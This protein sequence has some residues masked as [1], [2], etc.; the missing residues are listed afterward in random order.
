M[1]YK[2]GQVVNLKF[3]E[4]YKTAD[5]KTIVNGKHPVLVVDVFSN[6]KIRIASMSSNMKQIQKHRPH[7]IVLDD[8]KQAGLQKQ[9]YVNV[10]ATGIIDDSNV[11]KVIGMLTR[12]DLNKILSAMSQTKQKQILESQTIHN[13]GYP[14]YLD[15]KIDKYNRRIFIDFLNR[16]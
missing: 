10:S 14:E 3:N 6:D 5:L 8:W 7:D 1:N 13:T 16:L 12:K 11:Y 4:N 15:Y 9:T 2:P